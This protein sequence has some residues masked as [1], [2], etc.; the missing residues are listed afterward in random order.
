MLLASMLATPCAQSAERRGFKR[1]AKARAE[2]L[3][4]IEWPESPY[5]RS[6]AAFLGGSLVPVASM[7]ARPTL[8]QRL[9]Q[10]PF[11]TGEGRV[12]INLTDMDD[13]TAEAFRNVAE[14]TP[15]GRVLPWEGFL[16]L[17]E[18]RYFVLRYFSDDLAAMQEYLSLTTDPGWV[19]VSVQ[20]I[21]SG[22]VRR[23][24]YH[25]RHVLEATLDALEQHK[26]LLYRPGAWFVAEHL[27]AAGKVSE[28]HVTGKRPD[29]EWDYGLFDQNGDGQIVSGGH[30]GPGMRGAGKGVATKDA[31]GK[32]YLLQAEIR[33]PS[34]CYSCHEISGRVSPFAEFPAASDPVGD[35]HPAVLV[36]LSAAD[37][38]IVRKLNVE[39]GADQVMGQYGGLAALTL[40][41]W[42]QAGTAPTWSEPLWE[43]LVKLV[44]ELAR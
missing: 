38:E 10:S 13:A 43:R 2:E 27:D 18:Q 6:L 16:P 4:Q 28:T 41:A 19:T 44:P 23:V 35:Q 3:I 36:T 29:W 15:N 1:S 31:A 8:A 7:P 9:A 22:G 12:A 42:R 11:V 5:D 30:R 39:K 33:A 21:I 26:P 24:S 20:S 37:R 14:T 32:A 34:S 17:A 40:R 25:V